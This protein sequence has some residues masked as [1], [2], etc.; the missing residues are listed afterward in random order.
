MLRELIEEMI[1]FACRGFTHPRG[2]GK[3]SSSITSRT[4]CRQ[5]GGPQFG[6]SQGLQPDEPSRWQHPP[7]VRRGVL[8]GRPLC[9]PFPKPSRSRP[10]GP[11]HER[12]VLDEAQR[13]SRDHRFSGAALNAPSDPETGDSACLHEVIEGGLGPRAC[14]GAPAGGPRWRRRCRRSRRLPWL[15]LPR[16]SRRTRRSPALDRRPAYRPRW[17]G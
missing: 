15:R 11:Q 9:F 10:H 17:R 5:G 1:A 7:L 8:L 14:S 3:S 4:S 16:P 12:S 13:Q 6:G 2:Q